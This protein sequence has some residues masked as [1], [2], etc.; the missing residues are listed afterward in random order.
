MDAARQKALVRASATTR[1]KEEEKKEKGKERATSSAPK[2]VEK[3]APKRKLT[4]RTTVLLIS[5]QSPLGRSSPRS[6]CLPSQAME[7]AKA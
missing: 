1:K 5:H 2:V 7:L 4:G 6:R 3:G